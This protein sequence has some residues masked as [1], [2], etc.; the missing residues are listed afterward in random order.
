MPGPDL[1]QVFRLLRAVDRPAALTSLCQQVLPGQTGPSDRLIAVVWATPNMERTRERFVAPFMPLGR[2]RILG[3]DV[4]HVRFGQVALLLEQPDGGSGVAAFVGRF[5]EGVAAVYLERP[6]FLPRS[7]PS[8]RPPKSWPT[9]L[10]RRG[11][12]L[13]HEWPWGPFV[14]ALEQA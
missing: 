3:A 13:P 7:G 11:W 8:V 2:D 10:G 4:S 1:E 12:L 9:P 14:I 5:G 6:G